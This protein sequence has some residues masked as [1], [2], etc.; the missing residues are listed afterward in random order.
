MKTDRVAPLLNLY[1]RFLRGV[2]HLHT[3]HS[4][5][6][7]LAL[8]VLISCIRI[9]GHAR[10]TIALVRHLPH[11]FFSS[12]SKSWEP[13]TYSLLFRGSLLR[14]NS[15]YFLPREEGVT[16]D[17]FLLA[18]ETGLGSSIRRKCISQLFFMYFPLESL[19][20]LGLTLHVI[21]MFLIKPNSVKQNFYKVFAQVF[22]LFWLRFRGHLLESKRTAVAGQQGEIVL[23]GGKK[24]TVFLHQ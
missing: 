4:L 3:P 12:K 7:Q 18:K 10:A 19:Q 17:Y 22:Y 8:W 2:I 1:F 6:S 5:F 11:V 24:G 15:C 14:G 20:C 13:F 9:Q 23:K 21:K 16:A